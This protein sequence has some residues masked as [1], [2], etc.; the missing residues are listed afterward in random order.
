MARVVQNLGRGGQSFA[1]RVLGWSRPTIRKGLK[2]LLSGQDIIDRFFDRGR[3]KVEARF[4]S[5][6]DQ[7][8][9]IVEPTGQTDPTFRSTRTYI[10]LTAKSVRQQLIDRFGYKAAAFP[11]VRTISNKLTELDFR[12]M[13]V[14]KCRPLRKIPE[15]NAILDEVQ[16]INS[17]QFGGHYT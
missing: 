7:L 11:C 15:T 6:P 8:R 16:R 2:E 13:K 4:P 9:L 3:N 10:P 14:S 1:E 5:L 17:T 12:P